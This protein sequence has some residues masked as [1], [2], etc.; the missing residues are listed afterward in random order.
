MAAFAWGGWA[1][2]VGLA[3][4]LAEAK[5]VGREANFDHL[6]E[7]AASQ[8]AMLASFVNRCVEDVLD[9]AGALGAAE[10]SLPVAAGVQCVPLPADLRGR[11]VR[12]VVFSDGGRASRA[13]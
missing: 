12:K 11:D 2:G 8:R 1:M 13:A 5:A 3:G 6:G 9:K 4:L 7:D 10:S